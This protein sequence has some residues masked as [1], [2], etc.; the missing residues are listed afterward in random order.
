MRAAVVCVVFAL[1]WVVW[2]MALAEPTVTIYTDRTNY[3]SGDTIGVTLSV[4]N[5][6]ACATLDLCVGLLA[7]GGGIYTMGPSGWVHAIVPWNAEVRMPG[8]FDMTAHFRFE[9]PSVLP[10]PPISQDGEYHFASLC[11]EPGTWNWASNLGL[12]AFSYTGSGP[13]PDITMVSIPAGSFLMGSPEDEAGR[14]S[15]EG[16]Q[17]T[18][19]ISPF[20]MSETE[21][22]EKQWEDVM[23]WNDC[24]D[25]RGDNYPVER[26][27]W[28]DCVSF[29]NQLSEADG[30]VKCYEIT[31]TLYSGNHITS[32]DVACNFDA[33]G[34]RLPTEA[35]WEYACRAG[36]TSRFY[37]GDSES[38]LDRAGWY[39]CSQK[40]EVAQ[41]QGNGLGLY[42][43]HGNVW[44]WCWD[45][46]DEGYY[47]TQPD[48]DSDPAGPGSGAT[49]VLRGGGW[50]SSA[51]YCRSACRSWDEPSYLITYYGFRLCRSSN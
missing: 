48:P 34:Y 18:V 38:D 6:G 1:V 29:C 23:G 21:V 20:M 35:E 39:D 44:E 24:Y 7:P 50:G 12:A 2:T 17:R 28:Y 47:G 15:D 11:L 8:Q 16:P 14:F 27:A 36:T 5:P 32:A 4:E 46:Y 49:R 30:Y 37:T 22:T 33:N 13:S 40:H 43:T 31:N 10:A 45:W 42:D 26:V 25:K 51:L 19:H 3:Q 41:K 9:V